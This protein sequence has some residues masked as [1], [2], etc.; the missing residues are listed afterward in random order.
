MSASDKLF[1]FESVLRE[2][3]IMAVFNRRGADRV[4]ARH[5]D[6]ASR[7]SG[8]AAPAIF[9]GFVIASAI[10][11]VTGY[12][13]LLSDTPGIWIHRLMALAVA[14]S[15]L[16]ALVAMKLLP[17]GGRR[18]NFLRAGPDANENTK[19]AGDRRQI[20]HDAPPPLPKP[21]QRT[22]VSGGMLAGREFLEFDDGTI[23]IDTLVGRRRFIS[24]DAAREFVGA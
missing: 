4:S 6:P 2:S 9:A 1:T 10:V 11:F 16:I 5:S 23:E 14:Q 7:S 20:A 24:I 8:F 21:V 13:A 18:Q 19:S 17:L 15:M 12:S 3:A 22:P